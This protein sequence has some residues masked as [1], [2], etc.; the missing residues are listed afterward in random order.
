MK[1][2]LLALV[3]LLVGLPLLVYLIGL[4]VPRDHVATVSIDLVAPPDKVWALV[5]DLEHSNTWRPDVTAIR[6]EPA[7]DGKMRFTES[8]A[9]GDIGFEV[10]SQEPPRRQVVRVIDDDQPFGGT[11]TWQLEPLGAGTKL[12]VTEAGFVKSP[13]FRAM[14][15]IFFSPTATLEDYLRA[16][17]KALGESAEPRAIQS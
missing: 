15:L 14:G 13:I 12:T 10:L 17:A 6:L 8:G 11:W 4:A 16:L 7:V 9:Q 2:W 3:G 5:S 1:R